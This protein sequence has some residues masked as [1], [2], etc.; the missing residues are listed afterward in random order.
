VDAALEDPHVHLAALGHL[1]ALD[2]AAQAER[3]RQELWDHLEPGWLDDLRGYL[4][5]AEQFGLAAVAE[6]VWPLAEHKSKPVRDVAARTL[7]KL[8]KAA[9][10]R[11]AEFLC[12]PRAE[13]RLTAVLLLEGV[14]T[15]AAWKLLRERLQVEPARTVQDR[16]RTALMPAPAPPTQSVQQRKR[17]GKP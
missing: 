2:G 9:L 15:A 4:A 12:H 10:P 13:V 11:A 8:G 6:R 17:K 1:M 5:L 14:G 7:S 16:L 3:I